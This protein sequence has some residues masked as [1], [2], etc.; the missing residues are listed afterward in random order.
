MRVVHYTK[1]RENYKE[2]LKELGY[3]EKLYGLHSFR[4]GGA[5]TIAKSL[6]APNKEKLV[7]LYGRWKTDISKNYMYIKE[8]KVERLMVSKSIGI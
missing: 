2:C 1:F 6:N 8:D 3:D 7:E 4:A 5:T